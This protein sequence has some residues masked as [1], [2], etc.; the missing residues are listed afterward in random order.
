[1]LNTKSTRWIIYILFSFLSGNLVFAQTVVSENIKNAQSA[2]ARLDA[3]NNYTENL[4]HV[5]MNML[6]SGFKQTI[7][8]MEVTLA[9]SGAEFFPEY[10]SL[11]L[12]L[13]VKIP[14][15]KGKTLFFGAKDIKLSHD[16]DI[17]GSAQLTLLGDIEIPVSGENVIL[18][19]KGSMNAQT[20]QFADLTYATID[21]KGLKALGL[22]AEV[23]LSDKICYPVDQQGNKTSGKVVG[24]IQTEMENWSDIVATISFPSFAVNGLNDF[25]WNVQDAVFDFSDLKNSQSMNFPQG[26]DEYLV[27]GNEVLWRGVYVRDLSITLPPQFSKESDKRVTVFAN[28]M[29]IDDN[30]IT[31]LFGAKNILSFNEGNASGWSFSVDEFAL[32]LMTNRLEGVR[33]NGEVGLPVSKVDRLGYYGEI[34]ADNKY[35]MRVESLDT[36]SFDVLQAKVELDPNSYL[37]FKVE[38][39]KFRPQAMLHGRM[40]IDVKLQDKDKSL[41]QFKGIE[42][43]SLNL[44]TE[45][46]YLSVEYLG[47]N[48]K[49]GLMNFPVSIKDIALRTNANTASLGFDLDITLMDDQFKGSTRLEIIGE[50]EQGRLHK[51][52]YSQ[53]KLERINIEA[54]I[55]EVFTLKGGIDILNNDPVYG[56]GFGGQIA[57]SFGEKS[58]LKGLKV[59][60]RT[61]FGRTDFRYW[62]VD[63]IAELPA[64]GIPVGPGINLTGFGGG[65]S[66]R[67]MPHGFSN[68]NGGIL[69]TT[70]MTYT[71]N[72]DSSLGIKASV[73]FAVP[74]KETIHGE[75]CFELSF[76][77]KGGLNYA[78]FYGYAQF[79]GSIP[80]LDK[81]EKVVGD[82]YNKI[83]EKEE[84]FIKGNKGLADNLKKLKQYKPSDAAA[85]TIPDEQRNNIGKNGFTAA[86]GIQFNFVESSFHA[87]FDTYANVLGGVIRGVGS[88][89]RAGQAVIHI[90]PQ[91]W[92]MHMG[93][94]TD[95]I[96]L[97]M[98]IGNLI[99]VETGSYLMV[100]TRIP[101]APEVP[102]EVAS[103]LGY[104]PEDLNYMKNLNTIGEGK[105]F[106]FGS[107]MKVSTGDLTFLILYANYAAGLGFDIMLKDY[108]DTECKGR[109]GAIGMD[110]WYANGQAYAYMHGEL[111]AKIN[112]WFMKAKIP[113]FTADIATLLQA[114]LPNPSSFKAY[115]AVRAKLLGLV[116]INCRFKI[117]IGE[118]C[119]LVIPGGS[120]LDMHMI[121][122]LSPTDKDNN[123][124]VFT[125]PQATFNMPIGKAFDVQDDSGEKT[126]RIQL[127]DFTLNDGTD[128]VGKLRWNQDKDAVS[129]YSHEI[130]AENQEITATVRVV[131]EELKNGRW[132]QVYT[133]GKEAIESKTISFNTGGAPDH[134]PLENIVY[135]YPVVDQK[136]YLNG[137]SNKGYIQLEYGQ[138]YLFPEEFKNQVV[139]KDEQGVEQRLDFRYNQ[140]LKRIDYSIPTVK[141]QT[142]YTTT[143]VSLSQDEAKSV[144]EGATTSLLDDK[145]EGNID[146]E[147]KQATAEIR[148]DLGA[149]LLSYDFS[150]SRYSTLKQKIDNINKTQATAAVISSDVLMFGYEAEGMEPFDLADLV[151]TKHTDNK[152][153]IDVEATLDDYFYK[154]KIY[155]LVYQDYPIFGKIHVKR[156]NVET[157]GVP[158]SKALPLRIEYMN[159]IEQGV[160]DILT[161]RRFPYYYN[162]P[163]VYKEDF[164]DLQYQ[165]INTQMRTGGATYE[166]F[167]KG[168]YP[169]I[170]S[171]KY[172]MKMQYIMPGD[173]KGS[174]TIFEFY[175][176]VD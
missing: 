39:N 120:P 74:K 164:V 149:V 5:D 174:S 70:G 98:G 131:F 47:Y 117:S 108:Q 145:E 58:P 17:V 18:R 64:I 83:I 69:T 37:E 153:L 142:R 29:I 95:R 138:T 51:W 159:R 80:G 169:F 65:L 122:D 59:E 96:G 137:E 100:G 30:G 44:K 163:A 161:E 43:R 154:Q 72:K 168:S 94:P 150:S 157:I 129:F 25:V 78:G 143:I 151:G 132:T 54:T 162:L 172:R 45:N 63:G 28:D 4:N 33:F 13:R 87:T 40:G 3:Q 76:N 136:Y 97:R 115:L 135:S 55:A 113:I 46:P 42:F 31:G 165:I 121:S 105:G 6:P 11:E 14:G 158:P 62:F 10:T 27:P 48:G 114:K 71:P 130:L 93:T 12:F 86:V 24:R 73:A 170:S 111:G 160:F 102:S 125:A 34:T 144:S 89:N 2:F 85:L 35:I 107:S 1:M 175:N 140:A 16:G 110:G 146:L 116:K 81:F 9:V 128:V 61:M 124:S 127:K 118:E 22:T 156:D 8:N 67:M 50:M 41:A 134:I 68:S 7:N 77:D 84:N 20:G 52:K 101:A 21:C 166:K 147:N 141:N 53:T 148:T 133:A 57:V 171:E 112:L 26:Y 32:E 79:L 139:Y 103:I 91:E 88:E 109:S 56:D 60:A 19:L 99:S 38:N 15:E 173:L 92:Y 152:P 126:F 119:E 36:L 66:Y 123:I 167:L 49:V 90:D 106:A 176:F 23:E 82:K 75:A 155:P 104:D